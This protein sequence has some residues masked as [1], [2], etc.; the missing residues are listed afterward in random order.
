ME[1]LRNDNE[2]N[3][4]IC[5]R[6]LIE[7]HKNF[8]NVPELEE[9]VQP[10]FDFVCEMLSSMERNVRNYVDFSNIEVRSLISNNESFSAT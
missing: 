5:L 1:T 2:D 8:R 4:V 6:I 3:A 9:Q 10:F 7:L